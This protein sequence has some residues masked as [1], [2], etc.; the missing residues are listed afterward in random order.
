MNLSCSSDVSQRLWIDKFARRVVEPLEFSVDYR[1]FW[2]EVRFG[3]PGTPGGHARTK[4]EI[5]SETRVRE[6]TE[7][8]NHFIRR[9]PI[10][11]ARDIRQ[12][13]P[14]YLIPKRL[15]LSMDYKPIYYF[16]VPRLRITSQ[17]RNP[18]PDRRDTLPPL[19]LSFIPFPSLQ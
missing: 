9:L 2:I 1:E 11:Y 17:W 18:E 15:E 8:G 14:K 7:R 19:I 3:S 5:V 6:M 13:L 12:P 16:P 10:S 4:S